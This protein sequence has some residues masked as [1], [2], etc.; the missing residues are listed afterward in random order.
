MAGSCR[1]LLLTEHTED[2]PPSFPSYTTREEPQ[3]S[4]GPAE[5]R[6]PTHLPGHD[7][8]DRSVLLEGWGR[9]SPKAALRSLGKCSKVSIPSFLHRVPDPREHGGGNWE[10][11]CSTQHSCLRNSTK[12]LNTTWPTYTQIWLNSFRLELQISPPWSRQFA[13]CNNLEKEVIGEMSGNGLASE[14]I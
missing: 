9:C 11:Q 2:I 7:Q 13:A 8:R 12:S 3:K 1:R 4:L 10:P 6:G 5:P 14:W